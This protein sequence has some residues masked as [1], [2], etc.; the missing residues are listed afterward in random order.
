MNPDRPPTMKEAIDPTRGQ[1]GLDAEARQD[2]QVR[3]GIE[4]AKQG[5]FATPEQ[6]RRVIG[7]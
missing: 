1:P 5:R 7:C 3:M 2:Q 6:V 4:A